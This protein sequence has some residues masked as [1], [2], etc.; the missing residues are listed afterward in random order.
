[1]NHINAKEKMDGNVTNKTP[2]TAA[3]AKRTRRA[4]PMSA[5][6]L[7][8]TLDEREVVAKT[9]AMMNASPRIIVY[10]NQATLAKKLEK[11]SLCA[12]I[13]LRHAIQTDK[14]E[15]HHMAIFTDHYERFLKT[16]PDPERRDLLDFNHQLMD[17]E[18]GDWTLEAIVPFM[19]WLL[20]KGDNDVGFARI[21]S[22]DASVSKDA[23]VNNFVSYKNVCAHYAGR[24]TKEEKEADY[25][26]SGH[27]ACAGLYSLDGAVANGGVGRAWGMDGVGN[28]HGLPYMITR[29]ID[30]EDI[31]EAALQVWKHLEEAEV[32][33]TSLFAV[34]VED[35]AEVCA[36]G[37][38]TRTLAPADTLLC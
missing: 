15:F 32:W 17:A 10:D 26:P 1:M 20:E 6:P 24:P 38:R 11:N 14:L 31:K 5:E 22:P 9:K 29:E 34:T 7:K 36:A 23:F 25:E 35:E 2:A 13:M 37:N 28:P 33:P 18:E 19:D 16:H 21:H 12:M 30:G 3:H 4:S 27:W 8:G